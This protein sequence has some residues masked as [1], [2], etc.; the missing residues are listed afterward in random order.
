MTKMSGEDHVAVRMGQ[1]RPMVMSRKCKCFSGVLP[2]GGMG[3]RF[4]NVK[5]S[6]K[7][8]SGSI[9]VVKRLDGG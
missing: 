2:S 6:V 3:K 1:T 9:K 5:G 8:A 4:E 7:A